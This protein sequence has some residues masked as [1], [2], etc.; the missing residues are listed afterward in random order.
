MQWCKDGDG[1]SQSVQIHIA[2]LIREKREMHIEHIILG[3]W[4]N[5][6]E[7]QIENLELGKASLL[8]S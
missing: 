7:I 4:N 3:A 1:L 2:D 8:L 5:T 6:K